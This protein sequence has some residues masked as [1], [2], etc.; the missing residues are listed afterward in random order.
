M[1]FTPGAGGGPPTSGDEG[2]GPAPPGGAVEGS[3]APARS[4]SSIVT[5]IPNVARD[6]RSSW[7]GAVEKRAARARQASVGSAAEASSSQNAM[8]RLTKREQ[9]IRQPAL[10]IRHP[11]SPMSMSDRRP[12]RATSFRSPPGGEPVLSSSRCRAYASRN[13]SQVPASGNRRGRLTCGFHALPGDRNWH[14]TEGRRRRTARTGMRNSRSLP[15]ITRIGSRTSTRVV[16]STAS[17][18]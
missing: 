16:W 18:L 5:Q 2:G 13:A 8:P 6:F 12:S 17:A 15:Q 11:P 7:P 4:P 1:A 14:R 3:V 10:A 9:T